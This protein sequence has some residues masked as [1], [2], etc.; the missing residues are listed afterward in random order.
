MSIDFITNLPVSSAGN[1][2]M[3]VIVDSFSKCVTIIPCKMTIDA[4]E[5]ARL[6]FE[7]IICQFGLPDRIISDRDV[8]F[9]SLFSQALYRSMGVK[10]NISSA[11]HP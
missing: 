4:A 8:R 3:I 11:F 1:N 7:K 10:L 2:C 5:V 6:F 9:T